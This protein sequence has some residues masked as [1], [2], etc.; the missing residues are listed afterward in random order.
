MA[1]CQID[2]KPTRID[3]Q[4]LETAVQRL[5]FEPAGRKLDGVRPSAW[6]IAADHLELNALMGLSPSKAAPGCRSGN[7]SVLWRQEVA[8][9][10]L[11]ENVR[12][13]KL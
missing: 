5:L 12:L 6:G 8:C 11:V 10:K 7:L 2:V 3:H 9:E 1:R 4:K 13:V